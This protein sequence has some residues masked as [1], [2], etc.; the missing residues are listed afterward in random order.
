[1]LS[2]DVMRI[3]RV[4]VVVG[5]WLMNWCERVWV[6]AQF[7]EVEEVKGWKMARGRPFI[8]GKEK[9]RLQARSGVAWQAQLF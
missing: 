8:N 7:A 2:D 5:G 1:L 4:E 3:D 9:L 6:D